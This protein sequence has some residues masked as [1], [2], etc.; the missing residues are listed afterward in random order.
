MRQ[1][2]V[3]RA[4]HRLKWVNTDQKGGKKDQKGSKTQCKKVSFFKKGRK[5]LQV[6]EN[7]GREIQKIKNGR[8]LPYRA[9]KGTNLFS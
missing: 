4:Q 9:K 5:G 6:I 1:K 2:Y 8:K 3:K 7:S